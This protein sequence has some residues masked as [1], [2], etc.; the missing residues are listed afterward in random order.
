MFGRIVV[1]TLKYFFFCFVH[2]RKEHDQMDHKF[3]TPLLHLFFYGS[4]TQQPVTF[5]E[6]LIQ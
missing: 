6:A 5:T 3:S 1:S 2:K 4:W